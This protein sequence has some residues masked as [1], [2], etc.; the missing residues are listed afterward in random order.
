MLSKMKNRQVITLFHSYVNSLSSY[1]GFAEEI[2]RN[3]NYGATLAQNFA[4]MKK[5]DPEKQ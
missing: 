3:C 2:F 4:L 1:S 5:G